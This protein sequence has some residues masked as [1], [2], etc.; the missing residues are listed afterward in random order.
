M[1][2]ANENKR[3]VRLHR[4]RDLAFS[5]SQNIHSYTRTFCSVKKVCPRDHAAFS[6]KKREKYTA[7][8]WS[9]TLPSFLSPWQ[10][11][12]PF[13]TKWLQLLHLPNHQ[14]IW[15]KIPT[16]HLNQMAIHH[17]QTRLATLYTCYGINVFGH[18]SVGHGPFWIA[19]QISPFGS[20]LPF[21]LVCWWDIISQ[22][23]L[24]KS[25]HWVQPLFGWS[26]FVSYPLSS[27]RWSWV[28]Q[29]CLC[30]A[31]YNT[32]WLTYLFRSWR[33]HFKDRQIGYQNNHCMYECIIVMIHGSLN[34]FIVLWNHNDIC[35]C[36]WF[37]HGQSYQTWARCGIATG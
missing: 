23:L 32:V 9:C 4:L 29:V 31:L 27:L 1:I 18:L 19:G 36:S 10:K 26:R 15:M 22:S 37:D 30:L 24:Q 11:P 34:H 33:W 12:A 28:L 3:S 13:L 25:S 14:S 21:Q 7:S 2:W 16:Q 17:G 5:E 8:F 6:Y 20:L 35:A